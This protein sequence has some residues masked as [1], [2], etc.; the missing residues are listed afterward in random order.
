MNERIYAYVN[1]L[2]AG[3][4]ED[5]DRRIKTAQKITASIEH[6]K[7]QIVIE[8][9]A[10]GILIDVVD[11]TQRRQASAISVKIGANAQ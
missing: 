3:L 8:K 1:G 4:I 7:N 2:L 10:L 11:S 9:I 6:E 5:D